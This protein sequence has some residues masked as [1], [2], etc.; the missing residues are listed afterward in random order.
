MSK[1][2]KR[3]SSDLTPQQKYNLI[4]NTANKLVQALL[5][6]AL[7]SEFDEFTGHP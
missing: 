3:D 4:I 2:E 1:N 7:E 6:Q 5:Q